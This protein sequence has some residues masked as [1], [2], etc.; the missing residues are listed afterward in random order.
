MTELTGETS[1][2]RVK[3]PGSYSCLL[4]AFFIYFLIFLHCLSY[5]FIVK[6]R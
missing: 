6:D 1:E 4:S 2:I 3:S 5:V